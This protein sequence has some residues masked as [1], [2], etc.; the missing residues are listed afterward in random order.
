M[1]YKLKAKLT[2]NLFVVMTFVLLGA[3]MFGAAQA[4]EYL[5]HHRDRVACTK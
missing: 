5:Q 1:S 3:S 4:G 2:H